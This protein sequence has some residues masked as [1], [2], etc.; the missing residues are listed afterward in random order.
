M[1]AAAPADPGSRP[2]WRAVAVPSEHG[3]WGLTL[4]PVLL[5][6]FVAPSGAGA[7]LGAAAFVAFLARTPL[8]VVLVDARRHRASART[9]LARRILAAEVALLV[10]LALGAT[11]LGDPRLWLPAVAAAPL[12]LVELW[13]DMRSRSRRLVPELAGAIG[14]SSVVAMIVLADGREAALAGALWAVLAARSLTSIPFVRGQ[15]ARL[16]DRVQRPAIGVAADVAAVLVAGGAA[17][18][19]RSVTP[20]AVAIVAIVAYQRLSALRPVDRAVTLGIRQ[21][22]VGLTLVLVTGLGVLAP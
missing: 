8:R 7:L 19:D 18:I 13:F 11:A 5:G 17:V 22:V 21:T 16:H 1:T 9:S 3:G 14:V 12:V 15:V 4:E 6:L 2:A 20:G 10:G